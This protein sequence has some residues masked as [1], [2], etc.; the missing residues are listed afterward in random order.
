MK[1]KHRAWTTLAAATLLATSF[2]VPTASAAMLEPNPCS[3]QV[4]HG[5]HYQGATD[6]NKGTYTIYGTWWN[7]SGGTGVDRV[8]MDVSGGPDSPCISVAY[9]ST[10]STQA[11]Q[12]IQVG[13][14]GGTFRAWVRC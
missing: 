13:W 3:G 5:T 14:G 6:P 7:C 10:G 8:M 11:G 9:G 12:K 2:A 1:L 4:D